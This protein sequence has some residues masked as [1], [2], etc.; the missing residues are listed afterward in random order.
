MKL[1]KFVR[2][3]SIALLILLGIGAV[4]GG[5]TL[6][7]DPSGELLGL[8]LAELDTT[9]FNNYLIPGVILLIMVGLLPFFIAYSTI[10]KLSK[11]EWLIIFQGVIL[12]IWL[13]TEIVMGIFDPFF[14]YTYYATGILLV[15]CGIILIKTEK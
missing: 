6:I 10:R 5:V 9:P 1:Y 14:H 8:P 7:I 3:F 13:T 2:L 12:T 11:Y 4:Y 15:L